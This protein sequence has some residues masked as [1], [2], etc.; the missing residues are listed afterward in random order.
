MTEFPSFLRLN[1]I[2]LCMLSHLS[3]VWL[4]DPRDYS[5]S[6]WYSPGK[7]TRVGWH[8]LLQGI[9]LIQVLNLHLLHCRWI[10]YWLS[11]QGSHIYIYIYLSHFLNPFINQQAFDYFHNLA[12]VN[13]AAKNMRV[14]ISL[15]DTNFISFVYTPKWNCEPYCSSTFNFLRKF[16]TVLHSDCTNLFPTNNVQGLP[17]PQTYSYQGRRGEG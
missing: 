10:L 1:N 8:T 17:F 14:Q 6:P 3:H 7:N 2:P 11:H 15:R 12:L 9:F 4:C 16:Y 5:F 13:N